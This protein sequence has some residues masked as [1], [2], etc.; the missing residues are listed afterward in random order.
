M[1]PKKH[2]TKGN[3]TLRKRLKGLL[4]NI[5]SGEE[6]LT[7]SVVDILSKENKNY[8][9]NA[10]RAANLLRE[11]GLVRRLKNGVWLKI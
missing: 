10:Q 3:E 5:K 4:K 2:R 8:S 9:I 7:N 11:T 6:I 1:V